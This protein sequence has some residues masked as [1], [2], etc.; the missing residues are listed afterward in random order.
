M[1]TPWLIQRMQKS[2]LDFQSIIRGFGRDGGNESRKLIKTFVQFDYMG[3]A[4]F[5]FG[6][7]PK[8]FDEMEKGIKQYAQFQFKLGPG[9]KHTIYVICKTV[10]KQEVIKFIQDEFE[11]PHHMQEWTYFRESLGEGDP[12]YISEYKQYT[13]G[14][15]DICN[16]FMFFKDK[17]MFD[18][19]VN[20]YGL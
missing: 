7:L 13:L 18:R 15:F 16:H 1:R 2:Y 14:W 8:A 6:A 19:F 12:K 5:E 20:F 9:G 4:E 11:K 3:S 10:D 17:T